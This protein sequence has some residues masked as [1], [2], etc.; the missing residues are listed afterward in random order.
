MYQVAFRFLVLAQVRKRIRLLHRSIQRSLIYSNCRS[1]PHQVQ[2]GRPPASSCRD[3]QDFLGGIN[4]NNLGPWTW[5]CE[6][7]SLP[8]P[9]THAPVHREKAWPTERLTL[10]W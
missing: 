7:G 5:R 2:L 10:G 8:R 1:V 9:S 3:L 6:G 4:I